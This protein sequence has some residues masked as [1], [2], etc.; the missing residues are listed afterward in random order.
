[1][2]RAQMFSAAIVSRDSRVKPQNLVGA[3]DPRLVA[4]LQPL[5][6]LD[7]AADE[8]GGEDA[9]AA[10]VEQVDRLDP[11]L[12]RLARGD[13]RVIAEMRIAVNDAELRERQPPGFEQRHRDR[14]ARL[15]GRV[16]KIG[17]PAA[18]EPLH[19]QQAPC[20]QRLEDARHAHP[21]PAGEHRLIEPGEPRLA[22]IVE[23]LADA[24]ADLAR[25]LARVDRRTHPAVD[26]EQEVELD[27]IGLH[28]RGHVGILQLA[29]ERLALEAG[30]AVHLAERGGGGRRQV[31]R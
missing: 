31:E 15:G 3:D 16:L 10:V 7:D 27:E 28:R 26:G 11:P 25:D 14:V 6:K 5:V 1:M 24:R 22:D 4:L 13:H 2:K 23:L 12:V 18:V 8:A 29:G 19:R 30:R 9:H 17:Q 20:R 21:R